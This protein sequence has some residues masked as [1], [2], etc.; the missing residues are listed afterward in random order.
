MVRS[1]FKYWGLSESISQPDETLFTRTDPDWECQRL[2]TVVLLK[3]AI[4]ADILDDVMYL[5]KQ[6]CISAPSKSPYAGGQQP[7]GLPPEIDLPYFLFHTA[8]I[9]KRTVPS[10]LTDFGWLERIGDSDF[11]GI[12]GFASLVNVLNRRHS[13][14]Y[15]TTV[16][17]YDALVPRIRENMS[18]RFPDWET[19]FVD[20]GSAPKKWWHLALW[21]SKIVQRRQGRIVDV[22]KP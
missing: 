14:L 7:Q 20:R 2:R 22:N 17:H 8:A 18:K 3:W 1:A 10:S 5:Q 11:E 15:G 12:E 9:L 21:M 13:K 16:D 4:D 19:S 6:K